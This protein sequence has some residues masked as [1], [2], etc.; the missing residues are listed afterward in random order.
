M[1][2]KHIKLAAKWTN[3]CGGK[4]D[5]D[6]DILSVSTR[7]WP[8]DGG[9]WIGDEKGFRK[10]DILSKPSAK[11][12]LCFWDGSEGTREDT[13]GAYS[14]LISADFEGDTFEEV[15]AKVEAW[16]QEQTDRAVAALRREFATPAQEG[17][18]HDGN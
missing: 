15:A 11:C 6:G 9:F 5:Y 2:E 13:G 3:D 1:A 8:E 14:N 18:E 12:S 16:A 10:N 7:Y 4:K 17:T